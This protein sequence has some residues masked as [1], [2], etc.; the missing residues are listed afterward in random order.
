MKSKEIPNGN[1]IHPGDNE[2]GRGPGPVMCCWINFHPAIHRLTII[3][4]LPSELIEA[5]K[6]RKPREKK[7]SPRAACNARNDVNENETKSL[8]FHEFLKSRES[9]RN[10]NRELGGQIALIILLSGDF[11]LN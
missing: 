5:N 2:V 10:T 1:F 7:L 8:R 11:D 3:R 6:E 9:I 4:K